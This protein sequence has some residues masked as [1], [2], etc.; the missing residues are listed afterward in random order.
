MLLQVLCLLGVVAAEPDTLSRD[1]LLAKQEA[2]QAKL[3]YLNKAEEAKMR[4]HVDSVAAREDTNGTVTSLVRPIVY[5]PHDRLRRWNGQLI[6]ATV[7]GVNSVACFVI[8]SRFMHNFKRI[9]RE[10]TNGLPSLV[11][12]IVSASYSAIFLA[13]GICTGM[14]GAFFYQA[15]IRKNMS[16]AVCPD[17]WNG[18]YSIAAH[19]EY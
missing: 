9:E 10:D 18:T 1:S 17:L 15:G 2:L 14:T 4:L 19:F 3:D 8:A 12:S 5:D 7:L 11:G 6:T 13:G 16:I